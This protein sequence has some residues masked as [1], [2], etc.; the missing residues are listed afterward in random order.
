[1]GPQVPDVE[2]A[3]R[4]IS[5]PSH[6]VEAQGRPSSAIFGYPVTSVD[7]ASLSTPAETAA[8]FS[9]VT[10]V[11]Q[12][13]CGHARGNGFDTCHEPENGNESHCN[14]YYL[15]QTTVG[16]A[17]R[18]KDVQRLL[19][20]CSV[21]VIE[22]AGLGAETTLDAESETDTASPQL[23]DGAASLVLPPSSVHSASEGPSHE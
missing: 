3:Y 20:G 22:P 2:D 16:A 10:R 23:A 5:H 13:N 9:G 6:W 8:R 12:F 18:K 19:S 14:A 17:H 7:R 4:A 1:M 15:R 11:L 21:V